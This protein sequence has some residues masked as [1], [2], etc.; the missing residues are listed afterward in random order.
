MASTQVLN[1]PNQSD[2]NSLDSFTLKSEKVDND[3]ESEITSW[4]SFED[5][6]PSS[7]PSNT[8]F[9]TLN[10]N[11]NLQNIG[12]AIV[13]PEHSFADSVNHGSNPVANNLENFGVPSAG[14]YPTTNSVKVNAQRAHGIN[15]LQ[16]TNRSTPVDNDQKNVPTAINFNASTN[17]SATLYN[18]TPTYQLIAP[19]QHAS[20]PTPMPPTNFT[21]L[22]QYSSF[23]P[24][25]YT[26]NFGPF[27]SPVSSQPGSPVHPTLSSIP[28]SPTGS[29]QPHN[30]S[31]LGSPAK[32]PI[33]QKKTIAPQATNGN[34][35]FMNV[36]PPMNGAPA[37]GFPV[38]P[39]FPEYQIGP[40]FM[41]L[42]SQFQQFMKT[43]QPEDLNG[44]DKKKKA[45]RPQAIRRIR[46]TRPKVVEAKGGVQCKGKN[47]KKGTQCRN[48]ALMEYIGPR[49][50]YCAEHIELDPKSLYEKCKSS[51][52]KEPGD[53][54]GC[55]E[56]V[57][58]EFG[59][60]YKHYGDYIS[61]VVRNGDLEKARH[62]KERVTDLLA[63]LEREAAAAKKKDG[64]LYQR[65][66]KL[67]PK[68]QEMKRII[69]KAVETI[70]A[71]KN[72][73]GNSTTSSNE[74]LPS[75][76]STM[77]AIPVAPAEYMSLGIVSS[78]NN[79]FMEAQDSYSDSCSD[80]SPHVYGYDGDLSPQIFQLSDED[81]IDAFTD[82]SD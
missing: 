3:Q 7:N 66:N 39:F 46:Q 1:F 48:A 6:I 54:K 70:E 47:R 10:A 24:H 64:D 44:D 50:A 57:L 77:D 42:F 35:P 34:Q 58:K 49:P 43:Y 52:Q 17:G 73:N 40:Q 20:Q 72:L 37:N 63:Q 75:A 60:C 5:S 21:P 59:L 79:S 29:P 41:Q 4:L 9:S 28:N 69:T 15:Q 68:F 78:Q 61:Q 14:S 23:L 31:P 30:N 2:L 45:A 13:Q 71:S 76:P 12:D 65:K 18:F 67:I 51:Y 25:Q 80:D 36:H 22:T 8:F 19:S 56:V 62:Q 38:P 11:A 81:I 33:M 82:V 16:S 26:S 53:N 32:V 74:T 27:S 55:K